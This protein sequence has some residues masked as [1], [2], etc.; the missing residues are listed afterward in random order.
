MSCLRGGGAQRVFVDLANHYAARGIAVTIVHIESVAPL[1]ARIDPRVRV[2]DL[3]CSR[4]LAGIVPLWRWLRRHQPAAVISTM[5]HVN[6]ALI[7][8]GRVLP[9]FKGRLLV[10]EVAELGP[11]RFLLRDRIATRSLRTLYP[12]VD[13]ILTVS[14]SIARS[15]NAGR[16]TPLAAISVLPNPIDLSDI[17]ARGRGPAPHPWLADPHSIPVIL[18]VGR[19]A[20]EKD[21][22]TLLRAFALARRH[23]PLRL[24]ILGEGECRAGLEALADELE[25]TRDLA[26]PGF[27]DNPYPFVRAADLFVVSSVAEGF[28]LALAEALALGRSAVCTDCGDGPRGILDNGDL[29]DLVPVGDAEAMARAILHRLDAPLPPDRLRARME[30]FDIDGVA[31]AYLAVLRG[32][33]R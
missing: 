27:I 3:G 22:E 19:L 5:S 4:I 13:R 21:Y 32:E 1:R 9:G 30:R 18:S 28:S 14:D 11:G 33:V 24:M 20:L 15:L 10:Q 12:R 16:S 31:A 8:A 6:L 2:V 17:A 23:R 25:I 29:G 7:L 26:L